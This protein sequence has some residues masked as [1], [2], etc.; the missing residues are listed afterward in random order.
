MRHGRHLIA[1]LPGARPHLLAGE[2]L[3]PLARRRFDAI[4]ADLIA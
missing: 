1:R 4:V 3:I 2:G